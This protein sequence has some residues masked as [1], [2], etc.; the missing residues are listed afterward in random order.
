MKCDVRLVRHLAGSADMRLPCS[1]FPDGG[2]SDRVEPEQKV[3]SEPHQQ[4][5]EHARDLS[6]NRR[7]T[8][9]TDT[10]KPL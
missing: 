7:D 1:L 6:R 9:W 5:R 3:D 2:H 4:E 8:N 10:D